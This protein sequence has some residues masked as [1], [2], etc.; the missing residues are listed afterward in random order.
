[1]SKPA[2]AC[3][4]CGG[5]PLTKGH[6]WPDWI[7]KSL[8]STAAGHLQ[9]NGVFYTLDTELPKTPF[10]LTDRQG[11]AGQR[12]PRNTCLACNGGWMSKIEDAAKRATESLMLGSSVLLSPLDTMNIATLLCIIAVRMEF[13]GEERAVSQKERDY[14]RLNKFPSQSWRVWLAN[15]N[16]P[17]P[18]ELYSRK[19]GLAFSPLPGDAINPEECNVYVSTHIVG[20]LC[21]HVVYCPVSDF[22]GYD[23]SLALCQVWPLPRFYVDSSAISVLNGY[24][25]LHEAIARAAES[26]SRQRS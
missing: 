16:G 21:A 3:V 9:E 14:L 4:F 1:M 8:G 20:K 2:G 25:E 22:G 26:K 17:D 13:I 7:D 24:D 11:S 6:I 23:R 5:A 15:F 18:K 12:K 19:Y 10:S